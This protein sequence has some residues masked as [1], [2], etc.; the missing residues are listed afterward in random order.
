MPLSYFDHDSWDKVT[1]PASFNM[2]LPQGMEEEAALHLNA[3]R[4]HFVDTPIYDGRPY[5]DSFSLDTSGLVLR[6]VPTAMDGEDFYE[7]EQ[8]HRKYFPECVEFVKQMTGATA[9]LP[10][11]H[12]VRNILRM[13]EKNADGSEKY[14][15]VGGYATGAHND[16][17]L[18]S[19]PNRARQLLR[20]VP[21]VEEIL[22]HRYAVMNVWRRWDGGNDMPLAVCSGDSLAPDNSDVQ[23]SDLV[24]ENRTGE[25]DVVLA[26]L[27]TLNAH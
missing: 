25:I 5:A 27:F 19:G 20:P 10:F 16:N 23:G 17:T 21:E 11:D 7:I 9:V 26:F 4:A 22:S 3:R 1:K 15:G 6:H 8:V 13:R 14:P 2:T 12:S 18:A 24:Y